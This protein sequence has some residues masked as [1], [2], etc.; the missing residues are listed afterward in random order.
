MKVRVIDIPQEGLECDYTFSKANFEELNSRVVGGLFKFDTPP[1][2]SISL[3]SQGRTVYLKG[4]CKI[5][6]SSICA[7][8]SEPISQQLNLPTSLVIKPHKESPDDE[9][10][11]VELSYYDGKDLDCETILYD[12]FLMAL[13][14]SPL[15]SETCKGLCPKC[16]SNL[17]TEPCNCSET[18]ADEE[19][20]YFP[21]KAIQ[22]GIKLH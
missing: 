8:C 22:K 14:Y 7:R 13:P 16:G 15:C 11:D 17:N 6:F 9:V 18:A 1:Q 21:L 4:D 2:C 5:S 19:Q 10:D 3:T 12:F 20:G